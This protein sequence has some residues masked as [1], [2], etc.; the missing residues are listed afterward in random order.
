MAN[1]Q[2]VA[3]LPRVFLFPRMRYI[4]KN[5]PT[6]ASLQR[7]LMKVCK[8][9]FYKNPIIPVDKVDYKNGNIQISDD[10][11][12]I[13]FGNID[14]SRKYKLWLDGEMIFSNFNFTMTKFLTHVYRCDLKEIHLTSFVLSLRS[15]KIL[16]SSKT[17]EYLYFSVLK[18]S[19]KIKLI[20]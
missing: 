20:S 5:L 1:F 18:G 13:I 8:F 4:T 12:N 14:L 19:P 9:F 2:N 7:K 15:F 17:L 3:P 10:K 6:T 11:I 16:V